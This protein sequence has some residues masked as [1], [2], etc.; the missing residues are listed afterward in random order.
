MIAN[1]ASNNAYE[2][3]GV[4]RDADVATIRRAFKALAIKHHPDARPAEEKQEA[5]AVFARINQAHETLR[6]KEKRKKYDALLDRGVVPDLAK[7]V[8][9]QGQFQSLADIVGEIQAL[10]FQ[11][12]SDELLKS[13]DDDLVQ[14]MLLPNLI[15]GNNLQETVVDVLWLTIDESEKYEKPQGELTHGA[16]VITELRL[17]LLMT[18]VHTWQEGN[19]Q[20]TQIQWRSYGI[21]YAS[22]VD[23][24]IYEV[25]RAYTSYKLEFKEQDGT[26]FKLDIGGPP[27]DAEKK[28][29]T[30]LKPSRLSRLFLVANTYKLPLRIVSQGDETDEYGTA[31]AIG[32]IPAFLWCVPFAISSVCQ[33]FQKGDE[34][35]PFRP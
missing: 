5:T 21:G 20:H 27:A 28:V 14:K 19:V 13:V 26:R 33:L 25:G 32:L 35:D 3:L 23:L 1:P 30:P 29:K 24:R 10:D 12:N 9:E 11:R 4:P 6:D 17:I 15:H 2:I 22:L 7:D 31:V 8:G 16:L 18:F 34:C